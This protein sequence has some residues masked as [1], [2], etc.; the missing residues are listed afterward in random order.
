VSPLWEFAIFDP[1]L[2]FVEGLI[3]D[4]R[5]R[6]FVGVK[7]QRAILVGNWNANKFDLLNH[8]ARKLM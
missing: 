4:D 7:I 8:S 6:Q 1:A 5:E 3:G 2:L